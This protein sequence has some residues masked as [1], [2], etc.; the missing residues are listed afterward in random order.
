MMTLKARY[1]KMTCTFL[2]FTIANIFGY[3]RT[4]DNVKFNIH[5]YWTLIGPM[6][7][8]LISLIVSIVFW[9]ETAS[10][11][12]GTRSFLL[13]HKTIALPKSV[14]ESTQV[15]VRNAQK[16]LFAA[17]REARY[18]VTFATTDPADYKEV[19]VVVSALMRQLA[20]MSLMVQNERL[21]ML[22]HP[23]REND[24]LETESGDDSNSQGSRMNSDSGD[25][26]GD[27]SDA[28]PESNQELA[29]TS[30]MSAMSDYAVLQARRARK[31]DE[32]WRG[33][34]RS[35][36]VGDQILGSATAPST[37]SG[38]RKVRGGRSA[39][40]FKTF[41]GFHLSISSSGVAES[42][43]LPGEYHV[44]API[45]RLSVSS[46]SPPRSSQLSR[47][48]ISLDG[49]RGDRLVKGSKDLLSG[50]PTTTFKPG[51]SSSHRKSG[52][53]KEDSRFKRRGSGLD[54]GPRSSSRPVSAS[55]SF[56]SPT[57]TRASGAQEDKGA[58]VGSNAGGFLERLQSRHS[59]AG[60]LSEYQI[61]MA[62]KAFKAKNKMELKRS[63]RKEERQAKA[64]R[65]RLA[66]QVQE[67]EAARAI[68][69]K[70]AAFG[71]RKLFL[72]FLDIVREPLQR[73][74]D[75]CSRS[76]TTM[77]RE[78]IMGLNVE[79]DRMERIRKRSAQ[80]NVIVHRAA[81]AE[82]GGGST[83]S[84]QHWFS[85]GS[86][87]QAR[88]SEGFSR[89]VVRSA[90][91]I[92][93]RQPRMF[94]EEKARVTAKAAKAAEQETKRI[95][96]ENAKREEMERKD[97]LRRRRNSESWET[98]RMRRSLTMSAIFS[99]GAH[100]SNLEEGEGG[101]TP[102]FA[103]QPGSGRLAPRTSRLSDDD[104]DSE[105]SSFEQVLNM[106]SERQRL[107]IQVQS[108]HDDFPRPTFKQ[109]P[110]SSEKPQDKQRRAP[111]TAS[112]AAPPQLA[113]VNVPKPKSSRFR[114]WEFLQEFKS[115]EIR[116]GLKM[117]A[118][119]TFVGLWAW[120]GWTNTLL[121]TDRGQ[122]VMMTI[123]AV[124][125]PTIGATFSVCA[126]R[127]GGTVVGVL[128]PYVILAM[129]PPITFMAAYCI[130]IST[131]PIMEV[132]MMLSYNSIIFGLYHG[133]TQ[134]NIYGTSY[135][136]AVTVIIGIL[137]SVGLNTL[138][139]LVLA[140]RELRKDIALL[141]G[142]RGVLFAELS[143]SEPRLKENF[144][145]FLYK[146]IVQCCQNILDRMVSM[147]MAAQ[148]LSTEVR[149]LVTGPMNYYRRDMVG[150]LLLYFSVLSSSLA[151]KAP[152]PAYLPSARMARLRVIYNVRQAIAAHQA[153]TG[154][155]H[156]PLPD[157][158]RDTYIYYYAYSSALEEAIEELDAGSDLRLGLGTGIM[159]APGPSTALLDVSGASEQAQ[160]EQQLQLQQIELQM[161]Q[162]QGVHPEMILA[163]EATALPGDDSS[164]RGTVD[165]AATTTA[166]S[167]TL[168]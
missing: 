115:D 111:V 136:V 165:S 132:I 24:D 31:E 50:I 156:Y 67:E 39:N 64:E 120:L 73:L 76:M 79:K 55:G 63:R 21:L 146:Q 148:V 52:S 28:D 153:K 38:E 89:M 99:R 37:P 138:L 71:D 133:R 166:T 36:S 116:Y 18:E 30:G 29:S 19:R 70:E 91:N 109:G 90:Q 107:R 58:G 41:S 33:Q 164:Q 124:L 68:P 158:R 118:A 110:G 101:S 123:V 152:L 66:K 59:L 48:T 134:D 96:A 88:A 56:L 149:D 87:S 74:S 46:S 83:A 154:E 131:H 8:V 157:S 42:A 128:N 2:I 57:F 65:E 54:I 44:A 130:L 144:P 167:A 32:G 6:L 141:I 105:E 49:D 45:I 140:R 168:S 3:S 11:G 143:A 155:D 151:S 147:R 159:Q 23:D 95:A 121:A 103:P 119:L 97:R 22:G 72:S 85:W 61:D 117:A 77:E 15:E 81:A 34:A 13:N 102:Q 108:A 7:G 94:A 84:V 69:P 53:G 26:S 129:M 104:D 112:A 135:K 100:P 40:A 17:Y 14:I 10:E 47:R 137:I 1:A 126:W 106:D 80:R 62:A 139:R 75:S 125:S 86:Y 93:R 142:R 150:A 20:S 78:L 12:L 27:E 98:P 127:V 43:N 122:W 5:A 60:T 160:L 51:L 25:E 163:Q 145:G 114:V 162:L 4:N 35:P 92:E 113:F 161:Q 9:P 82:G 16:K